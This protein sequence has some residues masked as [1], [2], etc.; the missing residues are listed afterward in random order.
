MVEGVSQRHQVAVL[1]TPGIGLFELATLVE[2]FGLLRRRHGG[3]GRLPGHRGHPAHRRA[4]CAAD[5]LRARRAGAVGVLGRVRARRGGPARRPSRHD[6]LDV[7]RAARRAL[8]IGVGGARR[9]LRRRGAGAHVSGHRRGHRPRAAR[10]PGRPRLVGGQPPRAADG[11]AA[12]PGGRAG[13]VRR[14]ARATGT[15]PG[16]WLQQRRV[17]RA[18]HLLETTDLPVER[19]ARLAG[20]SSATTLRE[21]MRR[22]LGTSPTAYRTTFAGP[23]GNGHG[24]ATAAVP[25]AGGVAR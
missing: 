1:A 14:A 6:A 22:V 17:A 25:S 24:E 9:A 15:T 21:H 12:P 4:R 23:A 8:P 2:V 19:V 3:G 18:A 7:R 11:G 16:R 10:G 20:F 13:P 5:G